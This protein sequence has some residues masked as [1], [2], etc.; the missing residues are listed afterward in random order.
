D[1]TL[2]RL[3]HLQMVP[4]GGQQLVDQVAQSWIKTMV[5]NVGQP[6]DDM[7][8]APSLTSPTGHFYFAGDRP[9]LLCFDKRL[10]V[11]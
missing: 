7:L 8:M 3:G 2:Q 9:S 5:A 10:P 4:D 6:I 11:G 1:G